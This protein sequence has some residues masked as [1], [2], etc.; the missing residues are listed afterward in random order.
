MSGDTTATS[1]FQ[2]YWPSPSSV[3][4]Q[5]RVRGSDEAQEAPS[6]REGEPSSGSCRGSGFAYGRTASGRQ[7]VTNLRLPGQY[8]ERLL[9]S[10]GLQGPYYNWN[11][12]Y[13]PGVG[14]YLELDPIAMRGG[15]NTSYGPA[16]FEYAD[17]NPLSNTDKAGLGNDN[18]ANDLDITSCQQ[19]GCP[20]TANCPS[21]KWMVNACRLTGC[22]FGPRGVNRSWPAP[23]ECYYRCF[24]GALPWI[25]MTRFGPTPTI[26]CWNKS[27]D[28]RGGPFTPS[29]GSSGGLRMM[30]SH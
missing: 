8:D 22:N 1:A 5:N 26:G 21:K 16:W 4:D 29:H 25:N 2:G 11:R 18:P 3:S 15:F 9:G 12:W 23:G 7:K 30:P 28:D 24:D 19:R 6:G 10:V 14:R 17:Q 20:A 13:L 27:C